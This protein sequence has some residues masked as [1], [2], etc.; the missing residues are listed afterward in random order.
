MG[1]IRGTTLQSQTGKRHGQSRCIRNR[2]FIKIFEHHTPRSFY[3][4]DGARIPH[5]LIKCKKMKIM[6]IKPAFLGRVLKIS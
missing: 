4:Y 5:F 2:F 1:R 3:F 6:K